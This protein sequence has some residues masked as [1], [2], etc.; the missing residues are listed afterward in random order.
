[1][2]KTVNV[3]D[4]NTLYLYYNGTSQLA[5]SSGN[6]SYTHISIYAPNAEFNITGGGNGTF[7]GK[8]IIG[9]Y[10]DTSNSHVTLTDDSEIDENK[11]VGIDT[12]QRDVWL[13]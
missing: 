9:S 5:E 10:D 3:P 6:F 2:G 12:Y 4:G 8:M 7:L 1:L 11:V 13:K